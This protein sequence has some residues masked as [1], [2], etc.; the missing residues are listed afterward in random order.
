MKTCCYLGIYFSTKA[1]NVYTTKKAVLIFLIIIV[2]KYIK[3][4]NKYEWFKT[5]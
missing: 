3:K 1:E 4:L 5:F 2:K